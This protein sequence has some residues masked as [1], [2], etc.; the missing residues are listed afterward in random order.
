MAPDLV[1][2]FQMNPHDSTREVST[3]SGVSDMIVWIILKDEKCTH[4]FTSGT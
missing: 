1:A 4:I 3:D 2:A